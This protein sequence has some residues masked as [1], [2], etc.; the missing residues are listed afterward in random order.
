VAEWLGEGHSGD[1]LWLNLDARYD[2]VSIVAKKGNNTAK[3]DW[4]FIP[5][6]VG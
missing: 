1:F 4:C 3:I 2:F 5:F 6:S